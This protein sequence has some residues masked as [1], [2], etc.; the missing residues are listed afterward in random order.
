MRSVRRAAPAWDVGGQQRHRK[1]DARIPPVRAFVS[2]VRLEP[3]DSIG[4]RHILGDSL[5]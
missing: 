3:P 2:A 5:G 1:R 4:A